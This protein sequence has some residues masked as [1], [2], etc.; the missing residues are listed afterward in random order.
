MQGY[1]YSF[2]IKNDVEVEKTGVKED[3]VPN[4]RKIRRAENLYTGVLRNLAICP[5]LPP[6][7]HQTNIMEL[8]L[9][10][11][12]MPIKKAEKIVSAEKL[13]VKLFVTDCS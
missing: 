10:D 2:M 6:Y 11:Y 9:R 5:V 7:A 8:R 13:G 1:V 3:E 12:S 4:T